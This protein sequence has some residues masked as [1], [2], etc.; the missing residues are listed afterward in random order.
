VSTLIGYAWVS[1]DSEAVDL[2]IEALDR[3]GVELLF[4][5]LA[6]TADAER[7]QLKQALARLHDGRDTLVVWR[8]NRLGPSLEHL[9]ETLDRLGQRGIGFQSLEE[10]INITAGASE[11]AFRLVAALA[12]LRRD[13]IREQTAA[14]RAKTPAPARRRGRRFKLDKQKQAL[15]VML[16]KDPSNSVAGVCRKFKIGRT[17]LYRYVAESD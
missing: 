8:L 9:I 2:Q 3:A 11:P 5:D 6:A 17:T 14:G 1:T 4:A 16:Y 13:L 15:A 7:P 12:Q 10:D